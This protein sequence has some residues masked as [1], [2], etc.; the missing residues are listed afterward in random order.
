MF[1]V[2]NLAFSVSSNVEIA[3]LGWHSPLMKAKEAALRNLLRLL[4]VST[5]GRRSSDGSWRG[6]LVDSGRRT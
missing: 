6:S 3:D 5:G 1:S 2:H 4:L